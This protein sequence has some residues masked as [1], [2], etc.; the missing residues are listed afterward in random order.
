M[1]SRSIGTSKRFTVSGVLP[2]RLSDY[3]IPLVS[4]GGLARTADSA[5]VDFKVVFVR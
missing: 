3:R 5:T 2:I 1:A 4:A